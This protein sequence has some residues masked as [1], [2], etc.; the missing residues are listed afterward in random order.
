[1]LPYKADVIGVHNEREQDQHSWEHGGG[2]VKNAGERGGG[3]TVT[4]SSKNC[5][6]AT[7]GNDGN[8]YDKQDDG[9]KKKLT[10][11]IR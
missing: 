3:C 8:D 1:L 4:R 6:K 2:S 11:N 10:S 7:N 5:C 9:S